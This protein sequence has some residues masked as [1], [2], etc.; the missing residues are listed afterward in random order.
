MLNLPVFGLVDPIA[1][2]LAIIVGTLLGARPLLLILESRASELLVYNALTV[3]HGG[4]VT[5]KLSIVTDLN[6]ASYEIVLP[7]GPGFAMILNRF[8]GL[9]DLL[10]IV[11]VL[12][13]HLLQNCLLM[14]AKVD[15]LQ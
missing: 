6:L 12:L 8:D 4:L 11:F 14:L 5:D 2:G 9:I 13:L 15:Y 7:I 1:P 3:G 10:L